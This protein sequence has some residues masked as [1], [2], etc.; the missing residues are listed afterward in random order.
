M[1][2]T[3]WLP[4]LLAALLL[5]GCGGGAEASPDPVPDPEPGQIEVSGPEPEPEPQADP[6]ESIDL[7]LKPDESGKIMVLMY[8]NIGP[9]E[10]EWVR[11]PENFRKDLETLYE[12]GYRPVRLTDFVE[13]NITTPAGYTPVVITFDDANLNNFNIL[14]DGSVDP[15]CAFGMLTEF[16]RQHPDFPVHA[17]FFANGKNPFRQPEFL[18]VKMD[19]LLAAGMDLGNHTENHE[20]F[21]DADGSAIQRAIG[22]QAQYLESLVPE[23][24]RVDTLALPYGSRPRQKDLM[25]YLVEGNHGGHDYRNR[26]VLNVGWH[27]APSPYAADFDPA[28][29][30]RIR[31]SETKVDQVGMYNYLESFRSRPGERFIS[32]GVPEVITVPRDRQDTLADIPE[33]RI[34]YVYETEEEE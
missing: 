13:G 16:H 26:A 4:V 15:D 21:R 17:T 32:D 19:M 24:Y 10:A 14:E 8:H 20:N 33:D 27:P 12:E 6:R 23:G 29:I 1:R 11:T 31:A 2:H 5:T 28:S 25:A 22:A 30:P 9:E 7:D 18:D 34:L 3:R